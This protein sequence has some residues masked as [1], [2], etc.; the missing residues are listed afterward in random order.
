MGRDRM[1]KGMH[2]RFCRIALSGGFV[3]A[4]L[5]SRAR[6]AI[7]WCTRRIIVNA[8]KFEFAFKLFFRGDPEI[9]LHFYA[10]YNSSRRAVVPV[11]EDRQRLPAVPRHG[12]QRRQERG[13][14][15]G[16]V[17]LLRELCLPLLRLLLLGE[18]VL[19]QRRR[20]R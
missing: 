1:P 9:W 11:P 3:A 8:T 17:H 5:H 13:R 14:L 4:A 18:A 20:H 7:K 16:E 19:R 15:R 10:A 12:D 2:F 6:A